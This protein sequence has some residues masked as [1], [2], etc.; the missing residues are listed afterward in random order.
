MRMVH[1]KTGEE[2]QVEEY[3]RGM[4]PTPKGVK[5]ATGLRGPLA[6]VDTIGMEAAI[7]NHGD[8]LLTFPGGGRDIF[9]SSYIHQEYRKPEDPDEPAKPIRLG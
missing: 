3:T 6:R 2:V 7:I 8:Y 5:V 9:T 4:Y 1:R